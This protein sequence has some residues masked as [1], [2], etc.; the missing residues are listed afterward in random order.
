MKEKNNNWGIASLVTSILSILLVFAPYFG[1]PLGIIAVVGA[2]KQNKIHK[3]GMASAGQV[4][5]II[6]IV[7]NG[8]TLLF[9]GCVALMAAPY[10]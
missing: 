8:A 1:L 6:G 7:I 4:M 2:H 5:G 10:Y 3:T 9:I